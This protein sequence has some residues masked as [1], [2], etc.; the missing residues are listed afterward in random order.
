MQKQTHCRY[1]FEMCRYIAVHE[2]TVV[3]SLSGRLTQYSTI[4]PRGYELLRTKYLLVLPCSQYVIIDVNTI[5]IH[6]H[7]GDIV[8]SRMYVARPAVQSP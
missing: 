1:T 6:N 5:V 4:C 2:G 7:N 3:H 8:Y